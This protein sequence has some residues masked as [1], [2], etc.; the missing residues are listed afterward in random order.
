M[1]ILTA[2]YSSCRTW[3]IGPDISEA[4]WILCGVL[5]GCPLSATLFVLALQPFLAIVR[6]RLRPNELICACAKDLLSVVRSLDSLI[7]LHR[8]FLFLRRISGLALNVKK[9]QFIPLVQRLTLTTCDELRMILEIHASDF[10]SAEIGYTLTYLGFDIGPRATSCKWISQLEKHYQGSLQI[11]GFKQ[12]AGTAPR[13]YRICALSVFSYVS[14]L[15]HQTEALDSGLREKRILHKLSR[16][17]LGTF[18]MRS[19]TLT[20]L[21]CHPWFLSGYAA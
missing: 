1:N 2:F 12:V 18:P 16:F 11:I 10:A 7:F 5:Q 17:I 15:E 3:I 13:A 14:Q 4:I 20:P 9:L 6:S 19:L 21:D 8:A